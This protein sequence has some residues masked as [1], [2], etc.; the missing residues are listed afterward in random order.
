MLVSAGICERETNKGQS[1]EKESK[2]E[3][4]EQSIIL[5]PKDF[6]FIV[7][8]GKHSKMSLDSSHTVILADRGE[9]YLH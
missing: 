2:E 1:K 6:K 9:R 5:S 7:Y 3:R 4:F 8:F